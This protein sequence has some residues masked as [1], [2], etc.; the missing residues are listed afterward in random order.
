[1]DVELAKSKIL[2]IDK[3][4]RLENIK[5]NEIPIWW[6]FKPMLVLN[7]LPNPFSNFKEISNETK[8]TKLRSIKTKAISS[9]L[10]KYILRNEKNKVKLRHRD[11]KKS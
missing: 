4:T 3:N 1:M 7:S 2:N 5:L 8:K 11:L 9:I 10:K 6:F